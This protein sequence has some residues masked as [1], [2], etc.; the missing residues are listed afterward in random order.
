ILLFYLAAITSLALLG[1]YLAVLVVATIVSA[2][3]GMSAHVIAAMAPPGEIFG[4]LVRNLWLPTEPV[5]R[6]ALRRSDAHALFLIVDRLARRMGVAPPHEID[7]EMNCGAW[8]LLGGFGRGRGRTRLGVGYD[9]LAGL[10]A[11]EVEAVIAHELSHARL[12]RRGFSRWLKKGLVRL[13]R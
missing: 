4:V 6:L 3:F 8:V 12:V 5:Y 1:L 13:S 9:L 11:G 2:R 10:T 7:V